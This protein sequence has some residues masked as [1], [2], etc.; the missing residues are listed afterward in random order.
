MQK[1]AGPRQIYFHQRQREYR[2]DPVKQ[3]ERGYGQRTQAIC[4][5]V[6]NQMLMP[7]AVPGLRG[8]R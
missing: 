3:F 5:T 1:V 7:E 6:E 8:A 4:R 2:K